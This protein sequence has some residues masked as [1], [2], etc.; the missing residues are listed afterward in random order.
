MKKR[1]DA[2]E[3]LRF[4]LQIELA[5]AL[6]TLAIEIL[7]FMAKMKFFLLV[8]SAA[9]MSSTFLWCYSVLIWAS[10]SSLFFV[11]RERI[12]IAKD[13]NSD[14]KEGCSVDVV[15]VSGFVTGTDYE[16]K[17]VRLCREISMERHCLYMSCIQDILP[18]PINL[19]FMSINDWSEGE[20]SEEVS[21]QRA[22]KREKE[23]TACPLFTC[24]CDTPIYWLTH[25][26]R[27]CSA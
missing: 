14:L 5:T 10:S 24:V 21:R 23:G 4:E 6:G 26:L 12:K 11:S 3:E 13:C 17:A 19:W 2:S 8:L 7:D 15:P 22:L 25:S 9:G 16:V 18:L 1:V 20:D 27:S